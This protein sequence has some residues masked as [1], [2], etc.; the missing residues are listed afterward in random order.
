MKLSRCFV[1]S[2][3]AAFSVVCGSANEHDSIFLK[4][5]GMEF[6]RIAHAGVYMQVTEVT[7]AQYL[8]FLVATG[9]VRTDEK[10][11][12][13]WNRVKRKDSIGER[14]ISLENPE[15][16]WLN[17]KFPEGFDQHPV[18]LV[19]QEE[20]MRFCGWLATLGD[21]RSGYRL[22]TW[23]EWRAA[24]YGPDGMKRKCPWGNEMDPA[25]FRHS[26]SLA[27][28][29][30]RPI[31]L[32][33]KF[34]RP[35]GSLPAGAS[36]EGLLDLWGNVSEL[37]LAGPKFPPERLE[38]PN[39]TSILGGSYA[40]ELS[41]GQFSEGGGQEVSHGRFAAD[42]LGFRVVWPLPVAPIPSISPK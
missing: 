31:R 20:A 15:L 25:R 6:R 17:G 3:L 16:R 14:Q 41:S 9:Q 40:D 2:M 19:T 30:A 35:V 27:L 38:Y 26:G 33:D 37:V 5:L 8:S 1:A 28:M 22:P 36:P 32:V 21:K 7:N 18:V 24:A 4:E 42:D 12:D 11:V 10:L 29:T 13:S 39:A 34:T 23:K